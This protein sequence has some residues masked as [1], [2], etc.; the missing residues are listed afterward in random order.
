MM[1]WWG[2]CICWEGIG[3]CGF[4]FVYFVEGQYCFEVKFVFYV[5]VDQVVDGVM[6]GVGMYV[7]V[8]G[9]LFSVQMQC[10]CV[11]YDDLFF[12][13]QCVMVFFYQ[14]VQWF[15]CG[16]VECCQFGQ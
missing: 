1:F 9:L 15:Y 14:Q 6:V 12:L 2:C 16:D 4:V 3:L 11:V 8:I 5:G 7:Y 10:F 13:Q